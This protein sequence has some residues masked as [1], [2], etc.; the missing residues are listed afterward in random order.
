MALDVLAAAQGCTCTIIQTEHCV[1]IP[2]NSDNVTKILKDLLSQ[3][4][5][6]S[7]LPLSWEQHF[8]S[9]FSG[10]SWWKKLLLSIIIIILIGIY[11]C[12]GIYCCINLISVL[13]SSCFSHGALTS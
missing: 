9:W 13:M 6:M 3:I 1:Y 7:S 5:G 10:T 4:N 12:C 11:G 2:D 8:S